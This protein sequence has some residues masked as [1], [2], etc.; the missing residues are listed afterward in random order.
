MFVT[1][2]ILYHALAMF[3]HLF[4]LLSPLWSTLWHVWR[5]AI[6]ATTYYPPAGRNIVVDIVTYICTLLVWSTLLGSILMRKEEAAKRAASSAPPLRVSLNQANE[7]LE[8]ARKTVHKARDELN[9]IKD[10]SAATAEALLYLRKA[11]KN[12]LE[13]QQA[14]LEMADILDQQID[15]QFPPV[16]SGRAR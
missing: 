6:D 15:R 11:G 9:E 12:M 1:L 7:T 10:A 4:T 16:N 8:T 13:I 5:C 14:L 2:Y 3:G